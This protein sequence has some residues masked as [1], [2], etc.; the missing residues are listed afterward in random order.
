LAIRSCPQASIFNRS[1]GRD[2]V[3]QSTFTHHGEPDL[4]KLARP[5]PMSP[6]P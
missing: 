4:E 2:Q 6:A 3:R 5:E 1:F